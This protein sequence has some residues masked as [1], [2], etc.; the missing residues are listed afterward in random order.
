MTTDDGRG[1]LRG[2]LPAVEAPPELSGRVKA[3]LESRGL[4]RS[5]N[6]NR[7]DAGSAAVARRRRVTTWALG[8]GLDAAGFVIG[9]VASGTLGR[10]GG[11]P[12]SAPPG[13]YVVLLYGDPA[14][15][16]GA[17]HVARE[18]EYGRWAST[19]SDGARW[20]GGHELADVV[21]RLEPAGSTPVAYGDRLA[22]YFV[23][24]APSRERAADVARSC[25]PLKY[26]GR[27]VVMAVAS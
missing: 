9:L 24:E 22:G 3:T 10:A 18:Q 17:V 20:V 5:P 12:A 13:Q 11:R 14:D 16:T 2:P 21:E 4:L 6:D 23:I 19:L 7:P 25:P 8:A 15:D 26:G 1:S 27:V